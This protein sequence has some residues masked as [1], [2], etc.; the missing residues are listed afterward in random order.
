MTARERERQK[1]GRPDESS[2]LGLQAANRRAPGILFGDNTFRISRIRS[3]DG[4]DIFEC[5]MG[6]WTACHHYFRAHYLSPSLCEWHSASFARR[7]CDH[8]TNVDKF[9]NTHLASYV[10]H[11]VTECKCDLIFNSNVTS[12]VAQVDFRI[13]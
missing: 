1:H 2:L 12:A 5:A 3:P 11:Q 8:S 7:Q 13:R 6:N 4:R 9:V 10:W